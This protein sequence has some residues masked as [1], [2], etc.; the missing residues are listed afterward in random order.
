MLP[1]ALHVRN[2]VRLPPLA[3]GGGALWLLLIS[4]GWAVMLNAEFRG[5]EQ[6]VQPLVP[7]PDA[8]LAREPHR[9]ALIICL[10]PKCPCSPAA[11]SELER[12]LARP[13]VAAVRPRVLAVLTVPQGVAQSWTDGALLERCR[14]LPGVEIVIDNEGRISAG[15]GAV[16]SGTTLLYDSEGRLQFAGG[17]TIARGHEGTSAGADALAT[18]LAGQPSETLSTPVFG[19]RL[20]RPADALRPRPSLGD[21]TCN[22]LPTLGVVPN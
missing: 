1:I 19:C 10:H 12:L 13:T 16:A 20:V 2:R 4:A 6:R 3:V 18:L 9:P 17:L 21:P 15:F 14:Q 5:Y 8:L 7:W 22:E 11:L